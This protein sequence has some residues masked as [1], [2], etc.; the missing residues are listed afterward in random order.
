MSRELHEWKE[1]HPC[2]HDDGE[3]GSIFE[4]PLKV[5][6]VKRSYFEVT[7]SFYCAICDCRWRRINW[8]FATNRTII[9]DEE[10][11]EMRK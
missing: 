11:K 7:E 2:I 4:L 6:W 3:D 5:E 8:C 1:N 9:I 10:P